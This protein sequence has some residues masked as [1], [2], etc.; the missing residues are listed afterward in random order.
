[1]SALHYARQLSQENPNVS[2]LPIP[3]PD[4][5]LAEL[6]GAR[7]E[8]LG[9]SMQTP[10]KAMEEERDFRGV[11][12]LDFAQARLLIFDPSGEL[13]LDKSIRTRGI[14]RHWYARLLTAKHTKP[15][16]I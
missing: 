15:T 1:M 8:R 5:R 16:L 13:E 12:S 7:I 2:L 6:D 11:T 3:L 4:S 14:T 9:I 10:W